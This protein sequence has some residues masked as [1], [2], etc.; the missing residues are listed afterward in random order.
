VKIRKG[1]RP[2]NPLNPSVAA[3]LVTLSREGRATATDISF[4]QKRYR[5]NVK[6]NLDALTRRGYATKKRKNGN[7]YQYQ[8]TSAGRE[9]A[10]Q[11]KR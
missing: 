2:N 11:V 1:L 10:K 5:A 7:E 3:V 8:I 9:V 4:L 6:M